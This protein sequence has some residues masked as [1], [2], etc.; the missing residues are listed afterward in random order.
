LYNNSYGYGVYK[1]S[2]V[3]IGNPYQVKPPSS[4]ITLN[5]DFEE[6][7]ENE[8]DS[9]DQE[10]LISQDI[11]HKA[12]EESALIRREAELEADRIVCEAKERAELIAADAEQNA[13]EEGYR[14]GETIA[15]Q[16]YNDL[17][18]EAQEFKERS[19]TEYDETLASLEQDI[20]SL[21]INIAAKVV[22][23]EIRNNREAIL[24]I[25]RETIMACSN[26][27]H[28]VLKVSGEDYE[29]VLENEEKLRSMIRDLNE[30]EIRKDNSLA[31]GSCIID[32]GFGSVDGSSD[33]RM[34][35]IKEA[36]F[37]ILS[38]GVAGE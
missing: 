20:L 17:L 14:Y 26:R 10:L 6:T 18:A 38:G 37:E 7:P 4:R 28:V 8:D 27:D 24:G 33:V 12:K 23:D 31:R 32:T 22:G 35:S 25:V 29:T 3:N 2:Q 19:K 36:F 9:S 16:H 11:I 34:E 13:K 21:V 30:L 5:E 1:R 15:Q